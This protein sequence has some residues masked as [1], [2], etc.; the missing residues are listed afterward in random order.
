MASLLWSALAAS[1][2]ASRWRADTSSACYLQRVRYATIFKYVKILPSRI[3]F[4]P[5]AYQVFLIVLAAKSAQPTVTFT[6]IRFDYRRG[7]QSSTIALPGLF[8][9]EIIH[10]KCYKTGYILDAAVAHRFKAFDV[11]RLTTLPRYSQTPEFTLTPSPS[12]SAM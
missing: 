7:R 2:T 12:S 10:I 1:R 6:G 9:A 8:F 11:S 3:R 4:K 5:G